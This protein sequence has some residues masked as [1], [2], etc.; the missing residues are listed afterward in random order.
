MY[1]LDDGFACHRYQNSG[2]TGGWNEKV[3]A[4]NPNS[5]RPPDVRNPASLLFL[6]I[7]NTDEQVAAVMNRFQ[8]HA[9]CTPGRFLRKN[10]ITNIVESRFFFPQELQEHALVTKSINKKS[11]M[12]GVKRN[13]ERLAQCS[14]VMALGWLPSTDLQPAV[15]YK[16]LILY[17]ARYVSKPEIKSASY[18]E[19]Q[20]QV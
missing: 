5:T 17:V 9:T 2:A 4:M 8:M 19:L 13:V 18:Q 7:C 16:G 11:W 1:H 6:H 3:T 14:P 20:D 10:K 12:F 15:T